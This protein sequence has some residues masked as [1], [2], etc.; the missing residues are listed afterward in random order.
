M[1]IEVPKILKN[2]WES[3]QNKNGKVNEKTITELLGVNWE[4]ELKNKKKME[5]ILIE[6]DK[7][8]K[9]IDDELKLA[10]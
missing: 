10:K 2:Y 9:K 5:D 6:K 8:I 4:N 3:N 7:L 1:K